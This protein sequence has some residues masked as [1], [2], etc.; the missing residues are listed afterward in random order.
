MKFLFLLQNDHTAKNYRPTVGA[1]LDAGNANTS[2]DR[3]TVVCPAAKPLKQNDNQL[4]MIHSFNLKLIVLPLN[5]GTVVD[6]VQFQLVTS[7]LVFDVNPSYKV[8]FI[9]IPEIHR[10]RLSTE[11]ETLKWKYLKEDLIILILAV[12]MLPSLHMLTVPSVEDRYVWYCLMWCW[13]NSKEN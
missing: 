2:M 7:C 8:H 5:T 10:L 4:L 3:L 9:F 1:L 11:W 6:I 13:I 12:I